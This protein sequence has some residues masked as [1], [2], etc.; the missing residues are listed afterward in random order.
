MRVPTNLTGV[1]L[2]LAWSRLDHIPGPTLEE[3]DEVERLIEQ[4]PGLAP[5]PSPEDIERTRQ[6]FRRLDPDADIP[7]AIVIHSAKVARLF[8]TIKS[9]EIATARRLNAADN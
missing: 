6:S 8:A 1:E 5:D 4:H 3:F 9:L 2:H 7:D